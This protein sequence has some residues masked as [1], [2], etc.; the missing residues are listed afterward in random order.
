MAALEKACRGASER[1]S[2]KQ[3]NYTKTLAVAR[4]CE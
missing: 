3:F 2:L 4:T 1:S